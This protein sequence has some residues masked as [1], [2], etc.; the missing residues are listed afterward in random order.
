MPA[1]L[2]D[3]SLDPIETLKSRHPESGHFSVC[4]LADLPG[5]HRLW[6]LHAISEFME[7][8]WA[9]SYQMGAGQ[10]KSRFVFTAG[11][12]DWLL[13]AKTDFRE[14]VLVAIEPDTNEVAGLILMVPRQ[15]Q[16]H[17]RQFQSGIL[18]GLSVAPS[19][20]RRGIGQLLHF[21]AKRTLFEQNQGQPVFMWW[22][23]ACSGRGQAMRTFLRQDHN[24]VVAGRHAMLYRIF[25]G[26][27][28]ARVLDLSWYEKLYLTAFAD[29]NRNLRR[30]IQNSVQLMSTEDAEE[31]F[32]TLLVTRRSDRILGRRFTKGSFVNETCFVPSDTDDPFRPLSFVYRSGGKPKAALWGYRIPVRQVDTGGI[33]VTDQLIL[34]GSLSRRQRRRFVRNCEQI[35]LEQFDVMGNMY[36]RGFAHWPLFA[37]LGYVSDFPVARNAVLAVS[38]LSNLEQIPRA[39]QIQLDMK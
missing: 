16:W 21:A 28:A 32:D 10:S 19:H 31:V 1:Q 6:N 8:A 14:S 17:D 9:E 2:P 7:T 26:V 23:S 13:A 36:F 15:M 20:R 25:D 34:D 38:A 12:L 22:D 39:K 5:N 30:K 11:Y 29:R 35:A 27:A 24:V 3:K 18:T 33:M 37:S 4:A